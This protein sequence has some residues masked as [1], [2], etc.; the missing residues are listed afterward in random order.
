MR[1]AKGDHVA[2]ST[3]AVLSYLRRTA[4]P[5]KGQTVVSTWGQR[6]VP[7]HVRIRV[8]ERDRGVCQL[9]YDGCTYIATEVDHIVP[10]AVRQ[11][12]R[13]QRRAVAYPQMWQRSGW[14]EDGPRCEVE[15]RRSGAV[16][17][18]AHLAP[19]RPSPTRSLGALVRA[20]P[21]S[22]VSVGPTAIW[23]G[24]TGVAFASSAQAKGVC[25]VSSIL[26]VVFVAA[27]VIALGVFLVARDV[28][29]EIRA[30]N[31]SLERAREEWRAGGCVGPE[32][33]KYRGER[34]G[35]SGGFDLG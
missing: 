24:Q 22:S 31:Q 23:R 21:K 3:F 16:R 32:P 14:R 18:S 13:G 20:A 1:G 28:M 27:I 17:S 4:T 11:S 9:G 25:V 7:R 5:Q 29:R 12:L 8:L 33:V 10:V 6:G 35:D 30:S 2:V 34:W 15:T 19:T 26:P